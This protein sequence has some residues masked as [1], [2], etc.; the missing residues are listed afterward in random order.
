MFIN[1]LKLGKCRKSPANPFISIFKW[2]RLKKAAEKTTLEK[3]ARFKSRTEMQNKKFT[4]RKWLASYKSDFILEVL[5]I[6]MQ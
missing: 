4:W 5:V 3:G 2:L 6:R 1:Y